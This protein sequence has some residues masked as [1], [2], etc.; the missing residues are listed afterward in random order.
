MPPGV[1][2]QTSLCITRVAGI[3]THSNCE[4]GHFPNAT[5]VS[6]TKPEIGSRRPSLRVA[7]QRTTRVRPSRRTGSNRG[8]AREEKCASEMPLG[9][10]HS[11]SVGTAN[12]SAIESAGVAMVNMLPVDQRA[13]VP[14]RSV[15]RGRG[16]SLLPLPEKSC[17][18]P[19]GSARP[20]RTSCQV[21]NHSPTSNK[22]F[23]MFTALVRWFGAGQERP[24]RVRPAVCGSGCGWSR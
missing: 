15:A 1:S 3:V 13:A 9:P 10:Q 5:V 17:R 24:A 19:L 7:P 11:N 12:G 20:R 4:A 8:T 18:P 21:E 22:G 6:Q 2:Y 23:P 14:G 16:A